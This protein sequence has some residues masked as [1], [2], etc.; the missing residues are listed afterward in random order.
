MTLAPEPGWYSPWNKPHTQLYWTGTT[1]ADERTTQPRQRPASLHRWA[2][3]IGLAGMAV[4][5][6]PLAWSALS[7]ATHPP[8]AVTTGWVDPTS[9]V[10]LPTRRGP[11][12]TA[13]TVQVRI[14]QDDLKVTGTP[15]ACAT[16][17]APVQIAYDPADPAGTVRVRQPYERTAST[18]VSIAW[19]S[20]LFG[21]GIAWLVE[22][23]AQ[24]RARRPVTTSPT[25]TGAS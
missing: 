11:A 15:K 21:A 16:P 5:S 1:W 25:W 20:L 22:R 24:V 7:L 2:L 13:C 19:A 23:T 12:R 18:V 3:A 17:D 10:D 4:L 9:A 14:D 8:A 6:T